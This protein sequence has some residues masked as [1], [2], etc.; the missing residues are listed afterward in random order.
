MTDIGNWPELIVEKGYYTLIPVNEYQMANLL[1]A[2]TQ[3]CENGDWW[4]EFQDIIALVM[5]KRGILELRSN[6]GKVF[7]REQ[8][9]NRD[10]MNQDRYKK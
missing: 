1:D 4:H 9:F 6:S 10:I 2:L 3:S 5:D 7:T 8:V